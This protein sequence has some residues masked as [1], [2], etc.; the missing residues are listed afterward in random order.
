MFIYFSIFI[1]LFSFEYNLFHPIPTV[2]LIFTIF[3]LFFK[4]LVDKQLGNLQIEGTKLLDTTFRLTDA[5]YKVNGKIRDS[6]VLIVRYNPF[7]VPVHLFYYGALTA[8]LL[9]SVLRKV[10]DICWG[11]AE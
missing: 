2:P 10:K 11:R 1:Y 5:L 8:V 4:L 6:I 9:G 3:L 7:F